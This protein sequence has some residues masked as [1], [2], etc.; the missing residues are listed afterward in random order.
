MGTTDKAAWFSESEAR[1]LPLIRLAK[2]G[3]D[4]AFSQK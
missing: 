3:L 2:T 4:I 1:N